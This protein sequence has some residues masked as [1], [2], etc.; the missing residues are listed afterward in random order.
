MK[1]ESARDTR[2]VRHRRNL[3]GLRICCGE[4]A[5]AGVEKE[6]SIA[7]NPR[8]VRERQAASDHAAIGNFD[9][10]AAVVLERAPAGG[11]ISFCKCCDIA[12]LAVDNCDAVEMTAV[13][14]T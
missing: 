5:G 2:H 3:P 8:G 1:R 12:G 10:A 11:R 7:I 9:D 6:N 14:R 13:F 4:F